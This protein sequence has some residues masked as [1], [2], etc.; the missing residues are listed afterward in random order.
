MHSHGSVLRIS[1]KLSKE[2]TKAIDIRDN[3]RIAGWKY[4]EFRRARCCIEQDPSFRKRMPSTPTA[5]DQILSDLR[6]AYSD[7]DK[8]EK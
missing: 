7:P 2:I 1:K 8:W 3:L 4:Y 6:V 5:V